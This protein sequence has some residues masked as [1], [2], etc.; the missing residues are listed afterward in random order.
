MN[1][2]PTMLPMNMMRRHPCFGAE[3]HQSVGRI[4]LPVAPR[5]NIQC[6]FC[7]RRVC[8]GQEMQHPGWAQRLLT[9][10]Q[11]ALRVDELV[12]AR[13]AETFV[14]GVA[15]PGDPLANEGTFEALARVHRLRPWRAFTGRTQRCSSASAPMGCCSRRACHGCSRWV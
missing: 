14:V 15:G 6:A 3:A 2:S 5:C 9:P 11:A 7:E 1:S 4:H 8:A 12:A 13:P 10:D